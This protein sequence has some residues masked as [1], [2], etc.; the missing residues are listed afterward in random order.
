MHKS[1]IKGKKA[2]EED[3]KSNVPPNPP[4]LVT[5]NESVHDGKWISKETTRLVVLY[6]IGLQLTLVVMDLN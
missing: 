2:I 5:Y 3:L 1:I 4:L 6:G